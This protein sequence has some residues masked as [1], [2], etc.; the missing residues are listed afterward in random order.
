MDLC[1]VDFSSPIVLHSK[2]IPRDGEV[3]ELSGVIGVMANGS[4]FPRRM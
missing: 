3:S 1:V 2:G 4:I